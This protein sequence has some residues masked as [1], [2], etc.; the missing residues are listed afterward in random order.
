VATVCHSAGCRQERQEPGLIEKRLVCIGK[1]AKAHGIRGE[2]KLFAYSGDAAGLCGYEEL[3]LAAEQTAVVAI[4]EKRATAG[5]ALPPGWYRISQCRP[6]GKYT[7]VVLEGVEDREGA[8]AL[9][10]LLAHVDENALAPLGDDEFYWRQLEGHAVV[11]EEGDKI[12]RVSSLFS[13][14]AQDV[15][16]VKGKGREYYIPAIKEIITGIDP[17]AKKIT[18]A[19]VPGLLE[20]NS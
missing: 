4:P 13:N 12:G 10:G 15:L 3:F 1:V 9:V 16:V 6:Q 20:M 5:K 18:I 11:T 7:L 14:G 19:L 2:L 8:Q 17:I